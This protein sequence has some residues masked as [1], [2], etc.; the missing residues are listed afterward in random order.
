MREGPQPCDTMPQLPVLQRTVGVVSRNDTKIC[1]GYTLFNASRETYLI[2]EDGQ[3]V[4][5]WCSSRSIFTS[6]LLPS[7][8]LLRDG[9]VA[10]HAPGFQVGGAGGVV[11]EV[12]WDN[13]LVWVYDFYP[14]QQTLSH[15]DLE[16]LPNG[17]V[18]VLVWERKAKQDAINAGRRPDLIPDGEVWNNL[19]LELRPEGRTASVVWQWS[20]WDHIIQDV[21]PAFPNHGTIASHP[22]LF[23]INFCPV[24]GKHAQR[25]RLLLT[26]GQGKGL[27]NPSGLALWDRQGGQTGEKDWLHINCIS[28][29]EVRDLIVLCVNVSSEFIII[30]HGTTLDEAR[31]HTGGKHGKG[32]DILFRFGNPVACRQGTLHDQIFF[33]PHSAQFIKEAAGKGNVLIFNNGR[34]PDR[35]FS[36]VE[37]YQLPQSF[38]E[39]IP[40]SEL[41]WSFGPQQGKLGSFYC[42]HISGAQRLPNGNTLVVMG[43]QGILFEVTPQ[44]EEV[45]RYINPVRDCNGAMAGVRQ[46]DFRTEGRFSLFAAT[47]YEKSYSA[48]YV[49]GQPRQLKVGCYLEAV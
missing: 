6:Y 3:L 34:A 35:L 38:T 25:N 19:V 46:G 27:E 39:E 23:D 44:G 47:R 32:G 20:I 49:N 4:H 36:T 16:P 31:G 24:G 40:K 12:S 11:E 7:G 5:T 22:E 9:C 8:N 43:P 45:W 42:T 14:Y 30:D 37:E 29:D 41:I 28:F 2:D 1:S 15:H 26:K 48:F 18:L 17:N 33:S 13:Q 21:S 10:L